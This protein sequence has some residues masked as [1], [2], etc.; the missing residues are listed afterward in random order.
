VK[1]TVRP[2]K[3]NPTAE[4][5]QFGRDH[6]LIHEVIITGRKLGA[7]KEFWSDLAHDPH[8]FKQVKMLVDRSS[9]FLDESADQQA[10]RKIMGENYIGPWEAMKYLGLRYSL[11][12]LVKLEKIPFSH[13][14]LKKLCKT[15]VL[16][17][18]YPITLV[19]LKEQAPAYINLPGGSFENDSVIQKKG[20]ELRWYLLKKDV[21]P[22]SDCLDFQSQKKLLSRQEVVPKAGAL[23]FGMLLY[24][25]TTGQ[26]LF[27]DS[28]VRCQE[29][30]DRERGVIVGFSKKESLSPYTELGDYYINLLGYERSKKWHTIKMTSMVG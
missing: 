27:G 25:L 24:Y 17:V 12:Q 22:K 5:N 15:H 14:T 13:E 7:G 19:G 4:E 10:A 20:I 28:S 29:S 9:I 3:H 18:G 6:G 1:S 2:E 11:G 21:V 26:K 30:D 23:V 16:F 8:L